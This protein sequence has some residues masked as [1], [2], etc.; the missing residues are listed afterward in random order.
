MKITSIYLLIHWLERKWGVYF[1]KGG[2]TSLVSAFERLLTKKGAKII[3]NSS[4]SKIEAQA[5]KVTGVVTSGRKG[6]S[7]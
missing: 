2:T 1:A 5:G 4:V 6:L 7:L 3:K